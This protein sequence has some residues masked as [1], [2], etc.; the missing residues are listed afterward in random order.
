MIKIGL[1]LAEKGFI[2]DFLLRIAIRKLSLD[3]LEDDSLLSENQTL[4]LLLKR[5]Q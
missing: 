3:R 1:W 4:Q 2:P 5:E